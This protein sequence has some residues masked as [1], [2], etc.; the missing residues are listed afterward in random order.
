MYAVLEF[1]F[2]PLGSECSLLKKPIKES[3]LLF[4][5]KCIHS[6]DKF[7]TENDTKF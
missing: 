5:V 3:V 7:L 6:R 4:A 2:M 1:L